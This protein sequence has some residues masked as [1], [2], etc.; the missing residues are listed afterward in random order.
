MRVLH[1]GILVREHYL[2][3][4]P[5]DFL[6]SRAQTL[7]R[8]HPL[9]GVGAVQVFE[10]FTDY[11]EP[12]ESFDDPVHVTVTVPDDDPLD[13]ALVREITAWLEL[14]LAF[15]KGRL[16][17]YCIESAETW[18]E[19]ERIHGPYALASISGRSL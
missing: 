10:S 11:N 12:H 14:G 9:D 18:G 17:D 19:D 6:Y 2:I 5:V 16:V 13:P 15:N 3:A 4:D 7:M 8:D 1:Y